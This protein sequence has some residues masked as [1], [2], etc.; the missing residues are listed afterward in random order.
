MISFFIITIDTEG[1]NLWG[2][3]DIFKP[4]STENAKY[5]FRFQELCEKYGF[6]PT[7]LTNYEMAQTPA[8]IELGREGL[9]KGTLEIGAHE[10]AWN[11]P[12][13]YPLI[14]KPWKRG[15]PYLG[16]YPPKII[17]RK[18]EC[19]TYTLEDKFQCS[20]T[21]HR[22]GR[23]F[24]NRR[25]VAELD[26]LGYLVDCSCT[27]GIDWR[28]NPGWSISSCGTNW[29]DHSCELFV[30]EKY[31]GGRVKPSKVLEVPVTIVDQRGT[32]HLS[33]LRPDISN[34]NEI[35]S[36]IRLNNE[37]GVEYIEFILHSSE[38]MPG[39]SPTFNNKGKIEKLYRDLDQIF[40]CVK[41]SG[42]SGIGLSEY[43]R[44]K[45]D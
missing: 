20:I 16:E 15:K 29:N 10:H 32:G 11:Q 4:V 3:T 18:L 40:A 35:K 36:L 33:W 41:E 45:R 21:S 14:K 5:L 25:I 28:S 22:G 12:P 17:R 39:G 6:I 43:A 23:W 44:L 2:V 8:M 13:Y 34:L 1:D 7:Y 30:L 24:L 19:L 31:D 38:L 37:R 42:Y 26:R 9:K 27:P